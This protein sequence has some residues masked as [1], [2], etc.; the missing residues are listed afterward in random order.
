[1][2]VA[3]QKEVEFCTFLPGLHLSVRV[4][5]VLPDVHQRF[6]L[7]VPDTH[8]PHLPDLRH[9]K[10]VNSRAS[11]LQTLNTDPKLEPQLGPGASPSN[12]EEPHAC[13]AS[14][15]PSLALNASR[16]PL[17]ALNASRRPSQRSKL[18]SYLE[19]RPSYLEPRPSYLESRPLLPVA[20]PNWSP[21][22][23]T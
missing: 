19:P 9:R 17:L 11:S 21:A 20:P 4:H 23:T 12:M 16:R 13:Y 8:V 10:E 7:E 14:R 15:C 6:A 1:M 22:P 3:E 2:T 5:P 18:P